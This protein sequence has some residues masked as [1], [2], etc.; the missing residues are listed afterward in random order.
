MNAAVTFVA[1][2]TQYIAAWARNATRSNP[3]TWGRRPEV[4]RPFAA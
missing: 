4:V 3:L 1:L 2:A